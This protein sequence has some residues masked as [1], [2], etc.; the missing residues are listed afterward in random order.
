MVK[1]Y[2]SS[3]VFIGEKGYRNLLQ[4]VLALGV[5]SKTR[6]ADTK[7]MFG[8]TTKFKLWEGFPLF[9][10]REIWFKGVAEEGLFFLKGETD[11]KKLE[12]KGVKIW[13]GNTTR[14]FLDSRGLQHL[15]VGDM[16]KG[17]GFNLR[18]GSNTTPFDQ[19]AY[20]G[21]ELAKGA[22]YSRRAL[23]SFWLPANTAE[24][25]LPPCHILYV[26]SVDSTDEG[27]FLNLSVTLRSWD[28]WHG[29]PF[30]IAQAALFTHIICSWLNREKK[31]IQ[32]GVLSLHAADAHIYSPHF[33]KVKILLTRSIFPAP[34]LEVILPDSCTDCT[35]PQFV[36]KLTKESFLLKDYEPQPPINAPMVI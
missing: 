23:W 29:A 12:E 8:V 15:D 11:T 13:K 21:E 26:F 25:A 28:L 35:L 24:A 27:D 6:T 5:D 14:E 3:E 30:N 20:V 10:S 1:P 4:T 31:V 22:P 19:L 33:D 2:M 34:T 32:P 17:Y 7:K 36:D 16:G 9:T 18:K